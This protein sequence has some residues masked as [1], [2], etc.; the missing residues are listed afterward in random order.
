MLSSRYGHILIVS[1]HLSSRG[2]IRMAQLS[3]VCMGQAEGVELCAMSEEGSEE[4]PWNQRLAF[5]P[6]QIS[7]LN[8]L[9]FVFFVLD[10]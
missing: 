5:I 7:C 6:T 10:F 1:G 9:V 8:S 3:S 4:A 2:L